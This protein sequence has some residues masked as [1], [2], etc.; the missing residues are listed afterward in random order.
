MSTGLTRKVGRLGG[1]LDTAAR[2]GGENGRS[3]RP[4]F[5]QDVT[6]DIL[7]TGEH[8]NS[9]AK[10]PQ[11]WNYSGPTSAFTSGPGT[12][13]YFGTLPDCT[14]YDLAGGIPAACVSAAQAP[15]GG[16]AQL[17]SLALAALTNLGCYVRGGGVLTPPAY[18]TIGNAGRNIF[19]GPSYKNVDLSVAKDWKVKELLTV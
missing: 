18:G 6:T 9:I 3:G 11:T 17:Q 4:W 16:N 15:Y 2:T 10:T 12:I 1:G 14:S 8:L 13:P 7:G 5:P 19:S